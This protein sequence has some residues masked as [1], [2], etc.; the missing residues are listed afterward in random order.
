MEI[1]ITVII[2]GAAGLILYKNIK[3]KKTGG[4]NC[5][6]CS[7]HCSLYKTQKK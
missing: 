4:C 1:L 2:V 6:S 3:S 7:S 5:G